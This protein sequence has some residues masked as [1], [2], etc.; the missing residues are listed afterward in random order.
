[1]D[2]PFVVCHILISLDGKIDG[3]FFGAP[4]T[5]PAL[6]AY[7]E[8]RSFHNCQATVYGATTMRELYAGGP[9][10][11]L[12][13]CREPQLPDWVDEAGRATGRFIVSLDPE[14]T[15]GFRAG[16]VARRGRPDAH[17]I[18]VLTER[19]DPACRAYLRG[20]G[21]SYLTAGADRIDCA[22]LLQK[23]RRLFGIG[24]VMVAG[25]GVT[26]GAFLAAGL[27]D[28]LSLVVAPVADACAADVALFEQTSAPAAFR[29]LEAKPLDGGA[30]WL[31]Y[32][33]PVDL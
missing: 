16:S 27:L 13:P 8:L 9:A 6:G 22:L 17:I 33:R 24:R 5:A 10:P 11:K 14:G 12:P 23:L 15:L 18:E 30:L 4:E 32:E 29:L 2:R 26:N 31:R 21:V 1:M 25:G 3:A 19:A 28:E 7:G 20:Q